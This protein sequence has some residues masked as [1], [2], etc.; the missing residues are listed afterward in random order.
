MKRE[1]FY[2]NSFYPSSYTKVL[3]FI[4]DNYS[5][6]KNT[7]QNL[8]GYILPHA[9]WI[10]SG[11]VALKGLSNK[12]DINIENIYILGPSHRVPFPGVAVTDY[13]SYKTLN[14]EF[15]I[16]SKINSDLLKIKGVCV[17]NKAHDLEHSLEVQLEFLYYLYPHAQIIPLVVGFNSENILVEI[18]KYILSTSNSL[19]IISSDLSH[20]LEY[21]TATTLDK[22]TI[23]EIINNRQ[24]SSSTACGSNII[25]GF[26]LFNNRSEYVLKLFEYKNSGDTSGDKSRV[27]GYSAIGIY[28]N[29]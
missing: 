4:R 15:H 24:I 22:Y 5:E 10:Y 25:N 12:P 11:S 18:F 23:E 7:N 19:I 20:Y 21:N 27:V 8:I 29:G 28:K 1:I 6:S 9:G 13:K 3:E 16:N 2:S 26:T 14:G 17:N